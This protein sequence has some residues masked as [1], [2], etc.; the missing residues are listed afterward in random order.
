MCYD[1][2]GNYSNDTVTE[3]KTMSLQAHNIE[4]KKLIHNKE[5]SIFIIKKNI[6]YLISLVCV[7]EMV[8]SSILW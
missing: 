4:E 3:K 7:S 1:L 8:F 5:S 6:S 2:N